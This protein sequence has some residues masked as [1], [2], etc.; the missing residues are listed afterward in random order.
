MAPDAPEHPMR[1]QV[2]RWR[3]ARKTPGWVDRQLRR[4]GLPR[5]DIDAL[6]ADVYDAAYQRGTGRRRRNRRIGMVV[7]AIGVAANA[8][9]LSV[10]HLPIAIGAIALLIL[11]YGLLIVAL[12]EFLDNFE[13]PPSAEPPDDTRGN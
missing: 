11:V 8:V 5:P 9:T 3:I 10:S 2:V 7:A 12:P 4:R 13:A 1:D 6:L